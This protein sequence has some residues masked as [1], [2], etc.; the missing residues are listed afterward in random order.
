MVLFFDFNFFNRFLQVQCVD[1][2]KVTLVRI[3]IDFPNPKNSEKNKD[4]NFSNKKINK[5]REMKI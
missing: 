4:L 5:E 1:F 3:S 2:E